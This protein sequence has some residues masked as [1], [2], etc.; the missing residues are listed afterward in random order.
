MK[1]TIRTALVAIIVAGTLSA[2]CATTPDPE[3]EVPIGISVT[4]LEK[5]RLVGGRAVY[6]ARVPVALARE[7]LL[8]FDSYGSYRPTIAEARTI[9]RGPEGGEAFFQFRS[10]FGFEPHATCRFTVGEEDGVTVITYAMTDSSFALWALDGGF[11]LTPVGN[12]DVVLIDQQFLVSAL[13]TNR[14]ALL[15]E[16]ET[17]ARAIIEHLEAK[18]RESQGKPEKR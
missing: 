1:H 16:L 11:R 18:F 6:S 2:G 10:A 12:G 9:S 8:D 15:Q 13:V 3:P 17:D 5:G 4:P 7:T 14:Q